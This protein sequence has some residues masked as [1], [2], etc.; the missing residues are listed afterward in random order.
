MSCSGIR[1]PYNRD[2]LK[3][4]NMNSTEECPYFTSSEVAK[5]IAYKKGFS[6]GVIAM[7]KVM[8]LFRNSSDEELTKLFEQLF[9]KKGNKDEN[10]N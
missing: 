5:E 8:Q 10:N 2:T 4:C 3:E 9:I 6:D 1:C 7:S